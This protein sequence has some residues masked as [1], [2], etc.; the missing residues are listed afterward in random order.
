[1]Q[2]YRTEQQTMRKTAW[3]LRIKVSTLAS[4]NNSFDEN[5]EPYRKEDNRGKL[6]PVTPELVRQVI[7]LAEKFNDEG[8]KIFI[9]PF[10]DKVHENID[11]TLSKQT[12]KEILI[13][14]DLFAVSTR[15]RQ[16]NYY[17]SLCQCIP[18]GLISL[19]GSQ[20]TVTI[21][22][23]PYTFNVEMG[24]D[25]G[26][27]NHTGF[28]IRKTETAQ[29]VIAVLEEHIS[30]HGCPLGALV[31]HG[32]ANMSNEVLDF[33]KKHD[34][35]RVPV[36]PGNPKGNGTDEGAF[37][38]L[39]EAIGSIELETS[40]PEL[41][42]KSVLESMI[43]LY[44]IMRNK[45]SLR[46]NNVEPQA[47]ME[48]EQSE[49]VRLQER[50]RLIKHN[51]KREHSDEDQVKLQ[52]LQHVLEVNKLEVDTPSCRNAQSR[53]KHYTIEAIRKAERAFLKAVSRNEKKKNLAYFMGIVK[54]IQ[55]EMDDEKYR[56]YCRSSYQFDA[57]LETQR[58]KLEAKQEPQKAAIEQIVDMAE[59]AVSSPPSIQNTAR[60]IL[61]G[62][63]EAHL[64]T[65]RY[66]EPF[67]KKIQDT[68]GNWRGRELELETREA[69][70]AW[71][72]VLIEE[73]T[74]RQ[75]A[76]FAL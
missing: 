30:K 76:T 44:I 42:A 35:E 41:L 16:P 45:L 18:N 23:I 72:E 37:S 15:E 53:I 13:A 59:A 29:A 47:A 40:S 20:L 48:V 71:I 27:F 8:K 38:Q 32:S 46:R 2:F 69:L 14:N 25:V 19:D 22:K 34:I 50:E 31:D 17:G 36:G 4:W 60:T 3:V 70:W 66:L 7:K 52:A 39:K 9:A 63:L 73:I 12:V 55:Q 74:E 6:T 75:S 11:D 62:W 49:D 54:N 24:V 21:D 1:M 58:L 5:F 65:L 33:L 43:T 67:K 56:E 61:S 26:S 51:L 68:I 64:Q 28:D 10:T 57:M